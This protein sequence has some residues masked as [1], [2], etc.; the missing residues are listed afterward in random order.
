MQYVINMLGSVVMV[1]QI[2]FSA[3]TSNSDVCFLALLGSGGAPGDTLTP[4]FIKTEDLLHLLSGDVN[5]HLHDRQC[6]K[7]NTGTAIK[8]EHERA[9]RAQLYPHRLMWR[10]WVRNEMT[11]NISPKDENK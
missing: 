2:V 8:I 11:K 5:C 9:E 1:Q 3:L 6:C 4:V 7:A 10:Q